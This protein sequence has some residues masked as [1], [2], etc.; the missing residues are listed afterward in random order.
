MHTHTHTHTHTT[1]GPRRGWGHDV[2]MDLKP[3][4]K[5]VPGALSPGDKRPGREV[6]YCPPSSAEVKN[7]RNYTFTPPHVFMAWCFL[8]HRGYL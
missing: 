1:Q 7:A 8:K 3:P 4:M 6:G 5:W 2:G